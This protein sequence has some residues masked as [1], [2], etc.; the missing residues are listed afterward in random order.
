MFGFTGQG[1][2]DAGE[3]IDETLKREFM[4]EALG[5]MEISVEKQRELEDKLN[6]SVSNQYEVQF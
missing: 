6:K 5:K 2:V 4:E 3:I 1:M